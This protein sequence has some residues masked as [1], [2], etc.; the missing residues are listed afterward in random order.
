MLHYKLFSANHWIL[1]VKVPT[2]RQRG[3]IHRAVHMSVSMALNTLCTFDVDARGASLTLR[4]LKLSIL[5]L[6]FGFHSCSILG[7]T[8]SFLLDD[9]SASRLA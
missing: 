8:Y 4:D 6:P 9:C 3:I 2:K 7:V 5:N 1:V